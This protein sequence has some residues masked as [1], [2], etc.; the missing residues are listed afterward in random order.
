MLKA[1]FMVSVL[2][3]SA[4]EPTNEGYAPTQPIA[5]SHAVHAG[6]MEIPCQYCHYAAERGPHAGIP[7]A[8]VCMNCH[9]QVIPEHPEIQKV[10]N[11]LESKEPIAWVRVH[12]LPDHVFFDHSVHVASGVE[13]QT[14]HGQVQAMGKVRQTAPLTMG[15]C[16][17][18]HRDRMTETGGGEKQ[19]G[20]AVRAGPLSDCAVC[21]H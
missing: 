1:A 10:K 8:S 11:A 20:G 18:C 19:N 7:S 5:Y 15:W 16:L 13:C 6:A 3:L 17:S 4:C 12:S 14:C 2:V 21:H 9:R